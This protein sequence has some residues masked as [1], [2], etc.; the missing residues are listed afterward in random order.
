MTLPKQSAFRILHLPCEF[1]LLLLAA[2]AFSL[3]A[4][5]NGYPLVYSDTATYLS[6]GFELEPPPDRPITYGL[7]LRIFSL[8][9]T[10]LWLP[11]LF[12]GFLLGFLIRRIILLSHISHPNKFFIL[13]VAIISFC[14]GLA[15]AS[16]QLI[17]D[18]FT[19]IMILSWIPLFLEQKADWR[20]MLPYEILIFISNAMHISNF[21]ISL[22]ATA[23]LFILAVSFKTKMFERKR[24]WLII[25]PALLAPLTFSAACSKF[26]HV[27]IV[28]KLSEAKVLKPVLK[29]YCKERNLK[30]CPFIDS[31][32]ENLNDFIW[33]PGSPLQKMGGNDSVKS[34]FKEIIIYAFSHS[35]YIFPFISHCITSAYKQLYTDRMGDGNG[36]FTANTTLH[37]RICQYIPG[38]CNSFR[39]SVQQSPGFCPTTFDKINTI[40]SIVL[41]ISMTIILLFF[42]LKLHQPFHSQ[43][44]L[45]VLFGVASNA[46]VC[47]TL[48][49]VA[50][51][52]GC[53]VNGLMILLLILLS[54]PLLS[55][56]K[57]MNSQ[58]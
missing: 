53:R 34:E 9:G 39:S 28:A 10:T 55:R 24:I 13:T 4:I 38:D 22:I 42:I 37:Q 33:K 26:S 31:I 36:I 58:S 18:I 52:Y 41:F 27:F 57:K 23:F 6:S 19:P 21:L 5:L 14:S 3:P 46:L 2:I 40:H 17:A 1:T 48:T 56:N 25:L 7:F 12:Q 43:I 35:K 15:W 32:P 30:I 49:C 45:L 51:R 11:V 8:N 20:K 16:S 54:L 50:D 29:A 44:A 47:G